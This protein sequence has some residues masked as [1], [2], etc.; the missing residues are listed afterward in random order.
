MLLICIQ[1]LDYGDVQ[2]QD[3]GFT[4]P[5]FGGAKV[6]VENESVNTVANT[7]GLTFTTFGHTTAMSTGDDGDGGVDGAGDDGGGGDDGVNGASGDGGSGDGGVNGA[8]G[9]GDDA[10]LTP[11]VEFSG[12]DNLAVNVSP[13]VVRK[14]AN[15]TEPAF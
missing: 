9:D 6:L 2:V 12:Y 3:D 13:A 4:T 15:A 1:C 11:P 7:N 5:V 10:K 14:S 8:G